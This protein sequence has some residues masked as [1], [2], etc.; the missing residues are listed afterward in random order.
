MMSPR[1][2]AAKAEMCEARADECLN[3]LH[4]ADWREMAA[5]WREMAVDKGGQATIARLMGM[6]RARAEA[7]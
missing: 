4:S 3:T 2:C 7:G 1:C 5:R 6:D